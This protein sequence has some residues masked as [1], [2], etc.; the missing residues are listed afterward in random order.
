[1]C[2]EIVTLFLPRAQVC[3]VCLMPAGR[4]PVIRLSR[5]SINAGCRLQATQCS[6]GHCGRPATTARSG[7]WTV[8]HGFAHSQL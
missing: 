2:P 4:S 3:E 5:L 6:L 8:E 7:R 1:M